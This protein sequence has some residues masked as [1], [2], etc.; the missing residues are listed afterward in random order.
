MLIT[1]FSSISSYS[2]FCYSSDH[3]TWTQPPGDVVDSYE[4]TH[5]RITNECFGTVVFG[6]PSSIAGINGSM[7]SYSLTDLEED[8]GYEITIE[9]ANGAG[10]ATSAILYTRTS[11]AGALFANLP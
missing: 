8:S 10:R 4:I 2:D 6:S 3:L 11:V 5:Y 7:R 9:A 1:F